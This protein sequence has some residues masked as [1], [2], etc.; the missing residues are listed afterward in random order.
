MGLEGA[1]L[2]FRRSSWMLFT[3]LTREGCRV[4][5]LFPPGDEKRFLA[6]FSIDDRDSK[7]LVDA[8][9]ENVV[10]GTSKLGTN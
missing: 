8:V 7:I 5:P 9:V 1:E 4:N 3:I 6:Q 2:I 10:L